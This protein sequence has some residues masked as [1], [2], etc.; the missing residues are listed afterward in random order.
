MIGNDIAHALDDLIPVWG[1]DLLVISGNHNQQEHKGNMPLT[2][3]TYDGGD[4]HSLF[5]LYVNGDVFRVSR[6]NKE[7]GSTWNGDDQTYKSFKSIYTVHEKVGSIMIDSK[8][9]YNQEVEIENLACQFIE[10]LR[11]YAQND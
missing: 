6:V 9:D 7:D 4:G 5:T 2:T 3:V 8:V 11:E 1:D 10:C